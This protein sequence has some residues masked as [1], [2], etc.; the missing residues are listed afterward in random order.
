M[1]LW[2]MSRDNFRGMIWD[3]ERWI[4]QCLPPRISAGP[5]CLRMAVAWDASRIKICKYSSEKEPRG[6]MELFH[7]V[8]NTG[9][10][11]YSLTTK[12]LGWRSEEAF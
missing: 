1:W 5:P 11:E 3:G 6:R 9:A 7:V 8:D 10:N 4:L 12:H 2:E